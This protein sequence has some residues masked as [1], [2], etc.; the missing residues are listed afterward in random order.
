M[1]TGYCALGLVLGQELAVR[2]EAV[3]KTA[4]HSEVFVRHHGKKILLAAVLSCASFGLTHLIYLMTAPA[5]VNGGNREPIAFVRSVHDEVQRRPVTRVI[6]QLIEPGDPVYPGEAVKTSSLGEVSL[7]FADSKRRL[8]LEPDTLIVLTKSRDEISMELLDGNA[9]VAQGNGADENSAEPKLTLQSKNGKVDLSRATAS[10]S[11]DQINVLS[12]EAT[13]DKDGQKQ[14][15][16]ND[17]D[18]S[19]MR[20]TSPSIEETVYVS[21]SHP[22]PV[23][24]S[25]TG[26]PVGS[27]TTLHI[28][29]FRKTMKAI[30]PSTTL[31]ELSQELKPGRYY[32]KLVVQGASGNTLGESSV[33][34]LE[35]R[36]TAAPSVISPL[37]KETLT[38]RKENSPVHFNFSNPADC[39][40]VALEISKDAN[41]KTV[42]TIEKVLP[43]QSHFERVLP[44][45]K[46]YWRVTAHYEDTK[47][48][49]SS[50]IQSFDVVFKMPKVI[51]LAWDKSTKAKQYFVGEPELTLKWSVNEPSEVEKYRV[52][53]ARSAA[54]LG[55]QQDDSIIWES[56]K[57]EASG[58]MKTGGHYVAVIEAIDVGGERAARTEVLDLDLEVLP[59]LAAPVFSGQGDLAANV[60]GDLAVR[61][62]AI[63][64]AKSYFVTLKDNQGNP[65]QSKTFTNTNTSFNALLPG[66]YGLEIYAV[67]DYGRKS[68]QEPARKVIVP[69]T[70]G[71]GKPKLRKAKVID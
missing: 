48:S 17:G 26:T 67:D 4:A 30:G 24:F 61:W 33:F 43:T 15:F 45:G 36:G 31:T 25:W 2:A 12:G 1:E 5:D 27:K 69:E 23:K 21:A 57:T 54:A 10:L 47:P 37:N 62:S 68:N 35:V 19:K 22:K 63:D 70:S 41:F 14:E 42:Q 13:V 65:V 18:L 40:D 9:L 64:G 44:P 53:V 7:E 29:G 16:Q 59:L 50:P 11:K 51:H 38:F 8:D 49:S 39:I 32:W 60:R 71:L 28:G 6:W 46:Y 66:T 52:L 3:K 34:K 55:T 58:K 20:V 56:N